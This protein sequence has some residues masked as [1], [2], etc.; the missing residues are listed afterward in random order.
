MQATITYIVHNCFVLDLDGRTYL[1][2]YPAPEHRDAAAEEAVRGLLRGRDATFVV[3]HSHGDH[4]DPNLLRLADLAGTAR[5]LLSYD[6][7]EMHPE[8]ENLERVLLAEP[9]ESYEWEGLGVE[10]Y[11]STDL[12]CG[13]LIRD[14][15]V[16]VW[17]GGDVAEWAWEEADE[18]SRAFSIEHYGRTLAALKRS[19]APD[20]A[21]VNADKRLANWA[22]G[23]RFAR[24]VRPG[25]LVPMHV[26]GNTQ[27]VAEFADELGAA[28]GDAAPRLF[29]YGAT[30][31]TLSVDL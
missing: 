18:A 26:F 7:G 21:F 27:W 24:E 6:V 12:G 30:G 19:G 17:F 11:E 4:F 23:L 3:S 15:S 31:D 25:L 2:D 10:A 22:G 16:L 14:R 1:F 20:L 13:F 28:M 29:R 5:F 8:Y 9:E